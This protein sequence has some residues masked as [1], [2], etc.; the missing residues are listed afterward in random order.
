MFAGLENKCWQA[1]KKLNQR[2]ALK[3]NSRKTKRSLKNS[4]NR[5]K[6]YEALE[7]RLWR[8]EKGLGNEFTR[9]KMLRRS[10]EMSGGE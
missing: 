8:A 7:K 6:I 9:R 2:K 4:L 3:G 1:E 10:L 5:W